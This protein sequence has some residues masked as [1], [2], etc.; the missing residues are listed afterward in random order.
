[1]KSI[2]HRGSRFSVV[3]ICGTDGEEQDSEMQAD[4]DSAERGLPNHACP[5]DHLPVGAS[6]Q[7]ADIGVSM[8][9][10]VCI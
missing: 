6:F 7:S 2:V 9:M 5:S 4:P 1:M 10:Q 3:S 8:E